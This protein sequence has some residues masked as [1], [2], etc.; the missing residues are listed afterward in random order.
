MLARGS[1]YMDDPSF[2]ERGADGAAP[3]TCDPEWQVALGAPRWTADA[4]R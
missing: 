4:T 1:L 3:S 2:E